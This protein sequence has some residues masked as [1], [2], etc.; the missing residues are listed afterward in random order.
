MNLFSDYQK[1]IFNSL[2]NL[3]KKNKIKFPPNQKSF[4]VELPPK[5]QEADISCYA[6]MILAKT[7][8][9]SPIN[10]AET[11]KKSF[12]MLVESI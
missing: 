6:A 5:N 2:K 4:A 9:S 1:K 11:L 7:N 8:N 12:Q 10:L 3:E